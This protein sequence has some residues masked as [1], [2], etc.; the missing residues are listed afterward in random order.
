[1]NDIYDLVVIGSGPAGQSAAEVA[2]RF[3]HRAL[4]VE[5]NKPGGVVTTTGGVPTKT[6]R[7]AALYLTGFRQEEGLLPGRAPIPQP[8]FMQTPH[9]RRRSQGAQQEDDAHG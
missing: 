8:L 1:M 6:L 4:L 9:E 2:A 3:G 5:N 7:E